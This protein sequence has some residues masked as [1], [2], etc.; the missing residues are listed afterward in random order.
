MEFTS[1]A[2]GEH[3]QFHGAFL[4]LDDPSSGGIRL[5]QDSTRGDLVQ[6]VIPR[7]CDDKGRGCRFETFDRD[8]CSK[9]DLSLRRGANR[10]NLIWEV[11][12]T[13]DMKCE[14]ANGSVDAQL[15]FRGCS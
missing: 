3:M 9:L 12:G 14:L 13:L 7:S 6:V 8:R 5:E 11:D 15:T 4:Y 2:S 1:C 10:V